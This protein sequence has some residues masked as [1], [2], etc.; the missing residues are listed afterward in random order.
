MSKLLGHHLVALGWGTICSSAVLSLEEQTQRR[1]ECRSW[2]QAQGSLGRKFWVCF[3]E[4]RA[5][6]WVYDEHISLA[7]RESSCPWRA[8][9]GG[10]RGQSLPGINSSPSRTSSS[11]ETTVFRFLHSCVLD[12]HRSPEGGPGPEFNAT[13]TPV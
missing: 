8:R 10:Q 3:L 6:S 2:K 4:E 12:Y 5:G 13:W 1:G 9:E 7:L 11:M